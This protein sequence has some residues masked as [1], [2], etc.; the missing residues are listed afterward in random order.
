VISLAHPVP[1]SL[2]R[3]MTTL[4][5]QKGRRCRFVKIPWQPVYGALRAGE[6]I[7]LRLP[8]RADSLLGL[9][10]SAPSLINTELL[11]D[12][13]LSMRAFDLAPPHACE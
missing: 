10:R 4:A 3:M 13:E 7:G 8:F 1:V 9:V 5:A 6:R 12:L 2:R 11:A